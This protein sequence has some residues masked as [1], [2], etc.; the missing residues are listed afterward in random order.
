MIV[1]VVQENTIQQSAYDKHLSLRVEIDIIDNME[2][3]QFGMVNCFQLVMLQF[4]AIYFAVGGHEKHVVCCFG[5]IRHFFLNGTFQLG[6]MMGVYIEQI[7]L[8]FCT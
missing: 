1:Y 5:N 3:I 6:E 2:I 4:N 8:V 7:L